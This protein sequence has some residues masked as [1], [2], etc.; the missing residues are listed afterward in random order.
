MKDGINEDMRARIT[1]HY[2]SKYGISDWSSKQPDKLR[3]SK[4]PR[5]YSKK[6]KEEK[7]Y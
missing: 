3:I 1:Q 5:L 7:K 2:A 6:Q 4:P